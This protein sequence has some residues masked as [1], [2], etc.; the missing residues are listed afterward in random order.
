MLLV[1]SISAQD[2][3]FKRI[4]VEDYRDKV[5]GSWLAQCIGNIYGLPHENRYIDEPGPDAFPYGYR[6]NLEA[7]KRTNGVFSDDDTDIEYMY[8]LA[9]E[10]HG[11]PSRPW[12]N[13]PQCGN[14]T[15]EIA[16]GLRIGLPSRR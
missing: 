12:R 14:T 6:R 2:P 10:Q 13:S 11:A 8:L 3:E 4:A 1:S 9:M 5:Y 15:C 16:C 7:L